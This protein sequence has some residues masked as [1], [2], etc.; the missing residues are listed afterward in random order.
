MCVVYQYVYPLGIKYDVSGAQACNVG[1]YPIVKHRF[2]SQ[3]LVLMMATVTMTMTIVMIMMTMT[4]AMVMMLMRM[5]MMMMMM[6]IIVPMM[7]M[8]H[9]KINV[10]FKTGKICHLMSVKL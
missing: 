1:R 4:M 2:G 9:V 5:V 8:Y 6:I 10:L 7:M 3:M